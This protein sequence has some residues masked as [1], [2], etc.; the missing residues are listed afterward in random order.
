MEVALMKF[1]VTGATG[2]LGSL[3]IE[4]LLKTVPASDVV[5]SV[6]DPKK[7]EHLSAQG[8]EVREGDLLVQR[9]YLPHLQVSINY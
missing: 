2:Q 3:V 7:A 1:L 8:V 4:Q 5:A 9:H 6:R